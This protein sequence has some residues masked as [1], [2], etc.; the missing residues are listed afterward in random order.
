MEACSYCERRCDQGAVLPPQIVIACNACQCQS[1]IKQSR[2]SCAKT[3]P[4]SL[5]IKAG[6]L[7]AYSYCATRKQIRVELRIRSRPSH[8]ST[9]LIESI[10]VDDC[11]DISSGGGEV[12]PFKKLALRY[13]CGTAAATPTL[14]ATGPGVVFR[15]GKRNGVRLMLPVLHRPMQ[16]P[17][18]CLQ[19][20]FWLEK[21]VR[22]EAS[23]LC[24]S[25]PFVGRPFAH[26]H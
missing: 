17:G 11:P 14:G 7:D 20:R 10:A 16:I 6:N 1:R 19:I 25:R 22:I 9:T 23:D 8:F 15:Q 18:T 2:S 12:D 24:L 21:L 5:A 26:L 4:H 3:P 13:F